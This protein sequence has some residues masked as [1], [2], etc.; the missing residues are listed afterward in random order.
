[1]PIATASS[2]LLEPILQLARHYPPTLLGSE[3]ASGNDNIPGQSSST[4]VLSEHV[5]QPLPS[6]QQQLLDDAGLTHQDLTRPDA[7]F[8]ADRFTRV[9]A[10]LAKASN[11]PHISLRLAEATQPRMLGS[12]GFLISTSD[13]LGKALNILEE[14][15]PILFEGAQLSLEAVRHN[16]DTSSNK[17]A[18]RL[19]L[20]LEQPEQNIAEFFLA[21]LLNWPRWLTGQQIPVQRVELAHPEADD[22]ARFRQLFAAEVSFNAKENAVILPAQYLSLPCT[23]ANRE[24]HH[25]HKSFA[26]ALLGKSQNRNALTA[27]IRHLIREQIMAQGDA[28][29]REDVARQLGL[30]LRTLQR[31]LGELDTNFQNLYDETR[32][33][34]CLQLIRKGDQSFGEIA[35]QLGFSN[36][37]AFQKAFKRWVGMPPSQYRQTLQHSETESEDSSPEKDRNPPQT[38]P[39]TPRDLVTDGQITTSHDDGISENNLQHL[40]PEKL[41]RLNPFGLKTL[42]RAS[43]IGQIFS[44]A[45][46]ARLN[47][48]PEARLMIHLWPAQ[49]EGLIEPL[50]LAQGLPG[51]RFSS[52]LIQ[53]N[54]YKQLPQQD[55]MQLH[56]QISQLLWDTLPES[57][58]TQETTELLSHLNRLTDTVLA[59]AEQAVKLNQ[60]A[61]FQALSENRQQDASQLTAAAKKWLET[62]LLADTNT[63]GTATTPFLWHA[64]YQQAKLELYLGDAECALTTLAL[65]D[66]TLPDKTP[67]TDSDRID[68]LQSR[69]HQMLR[70][71]ARILLYLSQQ[72]EALELL[73]PHLSP[74]LPE[75]DKEQLVYLLK[76]LEEIQ[77]LR[78]APALQKDSQTAMSADQ[79][80]AALD[81]LRL[82]EPISQLARRQ[83]QPL[84]AACVISRMTQL[85]LQLQNEASKLDS[86]NSNLLNSFARYALVGYAWVASWFCGD[87]KLSDAIL[88]QGL[89]LSVRTENRD[90]EFFSFEEHLQLPEK[91]PQKPLG[92]NPATAIQEY[93]IDSVAVTDLWHT[94]QVQHWLEPLPQV[95]IKLRR[96]GDLVRRKNDPLLNHEQKCLWYQLTSIT[97]ERTLNRLKGRCRQDRQDL[98]LTQPSRSVPDRLHTELEDAGM[99]LP[100]LLQGNTQLPSQPAYKRPLQAANLIRAA[101]I[102][103]RQDIWPELFNWQSQ[104]E[105]DLPGYFMITETLFSLGMMRLI[106]SQQ[107][108]QTSPRRIR[109]IDQTESRFEHWSR[110]SPENFGGQYY[111]LRAEKKRLIADEAVPDQSECTT[112]FE[113]AIRIFTQQGFQPHQALAY[114]R[115]GAYLHSTGQPMLA[116]LCL[117]KARK[118]YQG[119]GA[120]AKIH[121]LDQPA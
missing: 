102:L 17:Q 87:Y 93:P 5:P 7:R 9:L 110:Q 10:R 27:Q 120:S 98:E 75:D 78:N 20:K 43:V 35:F 104:L 116:E 107:E 108:N 16:Q 82:L 118:L 44:L 3:Q 12:T 2:K 51:F 71:K 21:C 56:H 23:D 40:L 73:L 97:G 11:N 65:Y 22:P 70:L 62:H 54:L 114:E 41:Q 77:Q 57:L 45:F 8:P 28:I 26:D 47:R 4:P 103:N 80:S 60:S 72:N 86:Q 96:L 39:F 33:E 31:K 79:A 46:L 30:S 13:T 59:D 90:R 53:Q 99:L 119:W 63:I 6:L 42:Q 109:I 61:A 1:M 15:L 85:C 81:Q 121:R 32:K 50:E 19:V 83:S 34:L 106:L 113:Q 14:Y 52:H 117:Q 37:S 112:A 69:Q 95:L 64:I 76:T 49:E 25:L 84:L 48:E 101:L 88:K 67:S 105:N 24:L 66:A 89:A 55:R 92:L 94:G 58:P 100:D 68:T 29:R 74:N 38:T 115:Y 91:S 36:Q 18:V 111:L